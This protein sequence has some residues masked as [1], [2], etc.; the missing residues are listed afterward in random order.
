M[1]RNSNNNWSQDKKTLSDM[2]DLLKDLGDKY[3]NL[4]RQ[5]PWMDPTE[6]RKSELFASRIGHEI[7]KSKDSELKYTKKIQ[8]ITSR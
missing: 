7:I 6:L 5:G 1:A 3:E 4:R 8:D 2:K